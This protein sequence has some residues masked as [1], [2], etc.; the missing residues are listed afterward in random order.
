MSLMKSRKEGG[1][2]VSTVIVSTFL[3]TDI[4]GLC[5]KCAF[6]YSVMSDEE[7]LVRGLGTKK[8]WEDN[9]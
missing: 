6:N 3:G 1:P 8:C 7:V 4:E 5:S 2:R 9:N